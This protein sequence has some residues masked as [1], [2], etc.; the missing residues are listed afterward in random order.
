MTN[1]ETLQSVPIELIDDPE[2]A[3]RQQFDEEKLQELAESIKKHGVLQPLVL[4]ERGG[5]FEIIAGHRRLAACG[6]ARLGKVPALVRN[7]TD[8]ETAIL[9]M[10]ENL[11][12]EDVD[13]V[14]E[15]IFIANQIKALRTDLAAFAKMLGKSEQYIG[16]RLSIA[17]M[18]D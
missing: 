14:S 9:R 10:H 18:P 5:R 3:M 4:R 15:A 11:I 8:S 1:E 6:I 12:R 2:V 7:A 17:E 16:D 13:P